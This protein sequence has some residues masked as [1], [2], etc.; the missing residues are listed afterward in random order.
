VYTLEYPDVKPFLVPEPEARLGNRERII[1]ASLELFNERGAASVT[2]N[3]IAAHLSISPGN[4]YYHFRNKEEII[5]ALFPQIEAAVHSTIPVPPEGGITAADVGRY[6][7]A[8]IETLWNFR[9]VFRDLNELLERDPLLAESFR[10]LQRWV[11]GQ[12]QALFER[13][14]QQGQM[15]QPDPPEDLARIATNSFI[16]WSNWIRFLTTSRAKL[17]VDLIDMVDGALQGFLTFAPY[18]DP[19]FADEV[20]AVFD[21]RARPRKPRARNRASRRS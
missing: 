10:E 18:L 12:F 6:H 19:D 11:I 7:L 3:H 14:I 13:A 21:E 8:G 4:L 9:F 2:T 1:E 5:R 15:R 16:L 20:R 17:D